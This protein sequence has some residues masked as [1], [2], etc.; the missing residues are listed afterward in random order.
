MGIARKVGK[1]VGGFVFT[2]SLSFLIFSIAVVQLTE[3]ENMK[4]FFSDIFSSQIGALG[5]QVGLDEE[6]TEG[7]TEEQLEELYQTVLEMCEGEQSIQVSVTETGAPITLDCEE[8]RTLEESVEAGGLAEIIG[9]AAAASLFD[10]IYYKEFDCGFVQCLQAGK[11]DIM[12][13][14]QGH[15]F[16][17]GIKMYLVAAVT[18]SAVMIF[19]SAKTWPARMKGFGVP[20]LFIGLSYVMINLVKS[21]IISKFPFAQEAE[22]IGISVAPIVDKIVAPMLNSFL[23][24][25]ILGIALTAGAYALEYKEKRRTGIRNP[26]KK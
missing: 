3:Y 21:N 9:D 2:L 20:L 22:H 26:T 11:F 12:L 14:A 1:G 10:N 6:I 4:A 7:V 8:V 17:D 24:A 5:Q 19:V 18:V 16:L 15:E 13:S 25:L 23:I